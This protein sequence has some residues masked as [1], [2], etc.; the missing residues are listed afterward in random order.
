MKILAIDDIRD[1]LTV[2]KAVIKETF[3]ASAVYTALNGKDGIAL[4][5]TVDPDIILLDI[6]LPEEDGFEICRQIKQNEQLKL[7]PVVFLTAMK[8]SAENRIKALEAGADGFL[9]KPVEREELIAQIRAMVKIKA[10]ET[11]KI[12]EKKQIEEM[13]VE[14]TRELEEEIKLRINTEQKLRESEEKYH[15]L[16]EDV[17]DTSDVSVFILDANFS[18]VWVNHAT[19]KYFGIKKEEIIGKNKKKLIDEKIKWQLENPEEFAR[20]VLSTYENNTYTENFICHMLPG[21]NREDRWLKHWSQPIR[22]GL[23]KGGRIEHYTDITRL[24]KTEDQLR[25]NRDRYQIISELTSDYVFENE[26]LADGS[27]GRIWMAG[28]F[29]AMTGYSPDEFKKIGGWRKILHPE[30]VSIDDQAR[31]KL[32]HHKKAVIEVRIY[33]K[34][35]KIL[36]VRV[37]ALPVWDKK[38]NRLQKIIGSVKDIT[39]EKTH[40][41]LQEIL[42]GITKKVLSEKSLPKLFASV[43]QELN[44]VMNAR[45]FMAVQWDETTRTFTTRFLTDEKENIKKYSADGTLSIKVIQKKKSLF[46]LKKDILK[47]TEKGEITPK[48]A[49][50]EVWMG[51]PL[52]QK[53]RV[54]GL[55]ILQHY[56]N[57]GI[58]DKPSFQIFEAVANELSIYLSKKETEEENTRLSKAIQQNPISI[59]I[60]DPDGNIEFVNRAV[61]ETSGYPENEL[62]GQ[63]PRI[64]KSGEQPDNFY[65]E[66]WQTILSG[67][68]WKGEFHNKKKNGELYWVNAVIS[69]L[70][71]EDG[72][73]IQLVATEEDITDEK[74]NYLIQKAQFN[75]AHSMVTSLSLNDLFMQVKTELNNILYAKNFFIALL[76]SRTNRL[77]TIFGEDEKEFVQNIPPKRSLSGKVIKARKPLL[78]TRKEIRELADNGEIDLVG[79]RAELWMGAPLMI[80][81]KPMGVISVQCYDNPKAYNE[82]DKEIL[83]I[84]ANQLSLY[85]EQKQTEEFNQKLS[86]A[87][88][89][90]PVSIVITDASGTIE[91][92]NPKFTAI[93]GYTVKEAIGQNPRILKSG[94]HPESF[95]RELWNTVLSGK[96][97]K[98]ELLSKKKDGTLYWENVLISPIYNDAGEIT[99]L[100]GVMEDITGKKKMVTELI[101]AKE[102]AEE[103]DRLKSAFLQNMS[104]EI[105]T[106]LNGILGFADLLLNNS[107]DANETKT[108][109]GYIVASGNR[110]L[111]LINNI[112]DISRIETGSIS[113]NKN[114]FSVNK[115]MKEVFHLFEAEAKKKNISFQT[116]LFF[117]DE[118]SVLLSDEN[119]INQVLV[120]LIGNAFKFTRNGSINF[121]YKI[122]GNDLLFWVAD[123]GRGIAPEHQERIFERFY[124]AD[125]S[126]SRDFEGAGLGLPISKGLIELLG[127]KIW[128]ESKVGKGTTVYFTIPYITSDKYKNWQSA[129]DNA[130]TFS[131]H[132][133]KPVILIVEDDETSA[134]YIKT[135]LLKEN[136]EVL[137]V[138]TGKEA[139]ETCLHHPEIA[140]VLM[141]I[142]LPGMNG[143][144][145]TKKIKALRP[146]LPVIIQTAHAFTIDR[147]EAFRA[148][149]DDFIIKPITKNNLLKK[150]AD[151]LEQR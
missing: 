94:E 119:K 88:E 75:I 100:L 11:R 144:D 48:G 82:K 125:M 112:L 121:G 124:Q 43:Q 117:K 32:F 134:L 49:I 122:S 108:Y 29:E 71:D 86:K 95:Y 35:G 44:K 69:P 37:N 103:S 16:I 148:G 65:K 145:A 74:R 130:V 147:Q 136:Y 61:C 19:E 20:T 57:P 105:R 133:K 4:A 3:P 150:I 58:Y 78:F 111:S 120:N 139:I 38:N 83:S 110:L 18:V 25:E 106:P 1:N 79:K 114:P 5:K 129:N 107:P 27:I 45:N 115:L 66:M 60:T 93:T 126:I 70:F 135:V 31:E 91:Y 142:K 63:N 73:I 14:R 68:T 36:W 30:D 140:L 15:T 146:S 53:N 118:E 149:C 46:L 62:L 9:S 85:I 77:T 141:D 116:H 39:K 26:V 10:A 128:L 72:K 41:L 34:K 64:L 24:K 80:K 138:T 81:N 96:E 89:Q 12:I 6:I 50:P 123:T 40:Q 97:W 2:L 67:K 59:V 51:A 8:T 33:N 54:Y 137:R 76:D 55:M 23:Y 92:V 22:H 113:I 127:G 104:H 101:A 131:L 151:Q 52:F 99:H 17:L 13:V 28:S 98:G 109:A 21:E 87:T 7:I 132:K 90:S 84:I 143:L 47:M 42:F 56:Q 102:K